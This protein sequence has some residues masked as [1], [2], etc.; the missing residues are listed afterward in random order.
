MFIF[1]ESSV[2]F[3]VISYQWKRTSYIPMETLTILDP[4]SW[5]LESFIEMSENSLN[6]LTKKDKKKNVKM[7]KAVENFAWILTL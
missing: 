2:N 6:W 7:Q 4:P 1:G 5:S 3:D